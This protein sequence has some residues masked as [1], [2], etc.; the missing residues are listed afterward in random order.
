MPFIS[1]NPINA[2]AVIAATGVFSA[3]VQ[4][5]FF[6]EYLSLFSGNEFVIGM[7][8]SVW[9]A[10]SGLG[11]FWAGN[12]VRLPPVGRLLPVFMAL[13]GMGVYA[14]R[15]SSL[16]LAPGEIPGPLPVFLLC[17]AGEGPFAFVNGA[18]FGALARDRDGVRNPYGAESLGA[19]A[20]A[21]VAFVCILFHAKNIVIPAVAALPLVLVLLRKPN[22]LLV[23]LVL[24]TLP[25]IADKASMHW[26]YDFPFSEIIYGREGEIAV[27]KTG[28]D[29][30]YMLNGALYKSTAEKPFLEQAVH[31]PL[32]ARPYPHAALV[33]FDKGQ[34]R[35]LSKYPDLTVD[36]IESEPRLAASGC[37]IAAAETFQAHRRYDAVFSGGGIP[38]TAATSRLYTVSFFKKMKKMMTDSGVFSFSLP[39]SENYL[40]PAEKRLCD[41][42]KTTLGA[43]F[44]H[45]FV[46]PGDGY[47]FMASDEPLDIGNKPSVKTDYL[48]SSILPF[49]TAARI[50]AANAKPAQSLLNTPDR[51]VSLIMG[52]QLWTDLYRGTWPVV[53]GIFAAV[54]GAALLV[55]PKSKDVLSIGSTGGTVGIYSVALLLL[56]QATY[57]VLY[58]RVSI[59]LCSLTLGFAA[60]TLCKRLARADLLIGIYCLV[61]LGLLSLATYPPAILFYGAYAGMGALAGAQFASMKKTPAAT[62]YAADSIGGAAGMALTV[63]IIPLWGVTTVAAGLCAIKCAVW[64]Y[65]DRT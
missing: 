11:S 40:S 1:R 31:V 5:V 26:K 9:L 20:G 37:A 52:L 63:A 21:L 56:Y 3:A 28:N 51:P 49:A 60:G 24:L 23:A 14:L 47:T 15:A 36:C 18:V 59:L 16:L 48:E 4:C 22:V 33:I 6:R 27:I 50:Q 29:V 62:L 35:E 61:T 58:S 53:A 12:A 57:G 7:V 43:A 30:S 54:L 38:A 10:A 25:V 41:M 39:L 8:L 44:K 2:A 42:L 55:L 13:A 45:V 19:L 17:I 65:S 34:S 46:F 64:L 32:S